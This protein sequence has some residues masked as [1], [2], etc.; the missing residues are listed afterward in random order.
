M[1]KI[2]STWNECQNEK[3]LYSSHDLE[4]YPSGKA[5]FAP[6]HLIFCTKQV[7]NYSGLN[8]PRCLSSANFHD[9]GDAST[10]VELFLGFVQD[11]V[12]EPFV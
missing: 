8:L 3:R 7:G 5:E 1:I 4:I 10:C 11:F 9:V 2:I 6:S 12:F